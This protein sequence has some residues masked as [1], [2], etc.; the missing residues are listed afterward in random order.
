VTR[1]LAAKKTAA[2]PTFAPDKVGEVAFLVGGS[3]YVLMFC[4]PPYLV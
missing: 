2:D 3:T 1:S 4:F